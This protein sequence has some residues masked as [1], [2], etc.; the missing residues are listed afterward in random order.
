[1]QID[2]TTFTLEIINFLV[3]VWI[4]QRFL[5][6]PVLNAL[7]KRA[8]RMRQQAEDAAD[9]RTKAEALKQQYETRLEA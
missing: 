3:L 5:Y 7:D 1:M 4:L 8:A 6:R 2:W 9:A